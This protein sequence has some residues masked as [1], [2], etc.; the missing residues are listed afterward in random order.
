MSSDVAISKSPRAQWQVHFKKKCSQML[1]YVL[2]SG[3]GVYSYTFCPEELSFE[4]TKL[5][6]LLHT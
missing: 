5:T 4:T 2:K 6:M 1:H 3:L